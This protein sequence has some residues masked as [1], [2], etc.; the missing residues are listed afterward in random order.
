M[1]RFAL[2]AVVAGGLCLAGSWASMAQPAP[3]AQKPAGKDAKTKKAAKPAKPKPVEITPELKETYAAMPLAER[4]AIQS[5]LVWSGDYNG[6][7]NGEFGERPIAAVK[8]FQRR[9]GGKDTGV[10]APQERALLAASVKAQQ[11]QVGWTLIEDEVIPG[12]RLGIPAKF[13]VKSE[14][15][16]TGTRWS[17][18]RGE[19][20]IETFREKMGGVQLSQLF[21]EQKQTPRNRKV[22]YSALN[23][24]FFVLAGLQGLKKFYM[25]VQIK[26]SE[27]R[28]IT[29]LY[30]QA[31]DGIMEPVVVAMSSAFAPFGNS[32]AAG[33][34]RKVEY[35]SGIFV[36]PARHIVTSRRAIDDCHVIVV[37]GHGH[38]ERIAHDNMSELALL[39]INGASNIR[40]LAV[41]AE[42]PKGLELTLLGIAE[43][44]TQADDGIVTAAKAKLRGVEGS[45]VLLEAAPTPGFSG[46]AA[47][48]VKNQ[49]VGMMDLNPPAMIPA[50]SIR[51]FLDGAR[52]TPIE[53]RADID[54]AKAAI[55]R[56]ICV[57]K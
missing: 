15:G 5:D 21:E 36:S 47:L 11:Q 34:R 31:M 9:A 38:A 16:A 53:G 37:A 52:V 43:P 22:E 48:D 49:F 55:A 19:V 4:L 56:V 24:D 54:A 8:A 25:R 57:R 45:R 14:R 27:A 32:L 18:G 2:L 23:A 10:L 30:D 33:A 13:A 42:A 3:P 17:S 20:Q 1:R 28:G 26:D 29:I 6:L 41:S 51:R 46:A 7:I 50:A 35:A 40:P 12:A 39:R 44:Q